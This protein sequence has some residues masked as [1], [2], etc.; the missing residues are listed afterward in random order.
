MLLLLLLSSVKLGYHDN[1]CQPMSKQWPPMPTN[2]NQ[3]PTNVSN[4]HKQTKTKT[5]EQKHVNKN[6]NKNKS[7]HPIPLG[8]KKALKWP[9]PPVWQQIPHKSYEMKSSISD[10][11]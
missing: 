8:F 4:P 6:K 3:R 9:A 7:K 1:Q 10:T 11:E 2:A 5:R